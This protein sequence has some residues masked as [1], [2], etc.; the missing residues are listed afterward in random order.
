MFT[1]NVVRPVH[2]LGLALNALYM[3]NNSVSLMRM[4]LMREKLM[5]QQTKAPISRITISV[6]TFF[7][8]DIS[9]V[10]RSATIR[11]GT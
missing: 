6:M 3:V 8:R 9:Y 7:V 2:G 5:E 1:S 10:K 4:R 11:Q